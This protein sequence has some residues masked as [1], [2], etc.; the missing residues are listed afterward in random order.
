MWSCPIPIRARPHKTGQLHCAGCSFRAENPGCA[1][2]AGQCRKRQSLQLTV[3]AA[4]FVMLDQWKKKQKKK[5][6]KE[7]SSR[8]CSSSLLALFQNAAA[9]PPPTRWA[10]RSPLSA[11]E[12]LASSSYSM[13][14]SVR[15]SLSRPP[16]TNG[17]G[18]AER[19]PDTAPGLSWDSWTAHGPS[20]PRKL[21]MES[22]QRERPPRHQPAR[23]CGCRRASRGEGDSRRRSI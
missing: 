3:F 2:P 9:A 12:A 15:C 23:A 20:W 10:R 17:T 19:T 14:L 11:V 16:R 8:L 18:R 21:A 7:K 22:G 13:R 4:C 1:S 5:K 6:K